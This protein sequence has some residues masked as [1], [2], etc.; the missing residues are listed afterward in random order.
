MSMKWDNLS[1]EEMRMRTLFKIEE[2]HKCSMCGN[3]THYIDYC[4][5]SY[6]CSDECQKEFYKIVS[7]AESRQEEE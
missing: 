7:E 6:Y 4:S 3:N 2:T 5:E 1:E